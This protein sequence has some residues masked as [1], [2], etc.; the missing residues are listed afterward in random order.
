MNLFGLHHIAA[1]AS[2]R[3]ECV[4]FYGGL[5]GLAPAADPGE[6]AL[7]FGA[8][9]GGG[10]LSFTVAPGAPP[11]TAGRGLVHRLQWSVPGPEA[12]EYWRRR[13]EDA[14]VGVTAWLNGAGD[15]LALRFADPDGLDHELALSP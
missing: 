9:G 7:A 6:G 5:L 8:G 11:G 3:G 14:G 10:V 12:L 2:S 4:D 15:P 1:V 13:L